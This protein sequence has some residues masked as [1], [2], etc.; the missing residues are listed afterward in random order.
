M[1]ASVSCVVSSR[2]RQHPPGGLEQAA[3]RAVSLVWNKSGDDTAP[4][5]LLVSE[6]HRPLLQWGRQHS[7]LGLP[8]ELGRGHGAARLTGPASLSQAPVKIQGL[9][10]KCSHIPCVSSVSEQLLQGL[11]S[12]VDLFFIVPEIHPEAF[13]TGHQQHIQP[14]PQVH[15][16]QVL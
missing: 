11:F 2:R 7:C 10:A 4:Q 16:D 8:E 13:G 9:S 6:K 12:C 1:S 14:R 15:T 3:R 5:D